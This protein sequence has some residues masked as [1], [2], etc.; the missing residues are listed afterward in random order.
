MFLLLVFSVEVALMAAFV[1][2]LLKKWGIAEWMQVHGNGFVSQ[3]FSCDF[4]MSW[5]ASVIIAT[6]GLLLFNDAAFLLAPVLA[7]PIARYL[8]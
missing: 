5:W 3:L 7:T 2:V 8:V 4:C 6:A 1:V